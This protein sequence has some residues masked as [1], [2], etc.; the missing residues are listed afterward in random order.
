MKTSNRSDIRRTEV[1]LE[2]SARKKAIA[3]DLPLCRSG[4][5]ALCRSCP[6]VGSHIACPPRDHADQHGVLRSK[7]CGEVCRSCSDF[8]DDARRTSLRHT[9]VQAGLVQMALTA[10]QDT[11]WE[12]VRRAWNLAL[13]SRASLTLVT[14][15][16][17]SS[18]PLQD[19]HQGVPLD[20]LVVLAQYV[21]RI[22]DV[23]ARFVWQMCQITACGI[24]SWDMA[25]LSEEY[26]IFHPVISF[27]AFACHRT[28]WSRRHLRCS[29]YG[30]RVGSDERHRNAKPSKS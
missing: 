27:V 26:I 15:H 20:L 8:D 23:L 7:S 6:C 10:V 19:Y 3:E 22:T 12:K 11:A 16:D 18:L 5:P 9:C 4:V 14:R 28:R 24:M 29:G 1:A 17:I 21:V 30:N 13:V 25:G 2:R